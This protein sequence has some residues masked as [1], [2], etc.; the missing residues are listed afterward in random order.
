MDGAAS[1][2]SGEA[3]QVSPAAPLVIRHLLGLTI[4]SASC[5]QDPADAVTSEHE[6][7]TCIACLQGMVASMRH[8]TNLVYSRAADIGERHAREVAAYQEAIRGLEDELRAANGLRSG[9][10]SQAS[11]CSRCG[12]LRSERVPCVCVGDQAN[13]Q[14]M[15]TQKRESQ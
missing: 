13:G 4:G 5:G 7:V 6:T 2:P 10:V 11:H 14:S 3:P 12:W 9:P 15:V 1:K 8:V